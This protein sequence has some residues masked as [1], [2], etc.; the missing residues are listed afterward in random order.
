[1]GSDYSSY[2]TNRFTSEL[3]QCS[4]SELSCAYQGGTACLTEHVARCAA[5]ALLVQGSTTTTAAAVVESSDSGMKSAVIILSVV[6]GFFVV[7][8]GVLLVI[9]FHRRQT[10]VEPQLPGAAYTTPSSPKPEKSASV[11]SS[12]SGLQTSHSDPLPAVATEGS[13]TI[14][15]VAPQPTSSHI[16]PHASMKPRQ[17]N[18]ARISDSNPETLARQQMK[19]RRIIT[20]LKD[21]RWQRGRLLGRGSTGAVFLCILCDGS[22]LAM[23][24]ID[25]HSSTKE[26][27]ETLTQELRMMASLRDEHIIRYYHAEYSPSEKVVNLWMEYC[28]GGALG[29]LVKKLDDRLHEDVVQHYVKQILQGIAFLHCHHIVHRDIKGDNILIESEGI[30]KLADFGSAKRLTIKTT[31]ATHTNVTNTIVGT[32]L[33]MAPEVVNP[34]SEYAS[35][36]YNTKAD[37]WSLGITVA[38]LLDQGR[39][40]WP[41]FTS[42]WAALF[43]IG[44]VMERPLLPK[45]SDICSDF[46]NKCLQP[47]PHDRP[48][49]EQLLQHPWMVNAGE[50]DPDNFEWDPNFTTSVEFQQ[51]IGQA[52]RVPASGPAEGI[53]Y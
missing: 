47:N 2:C 14:I 5:A 9:V 3:Q 16:S 41:E 39:P 32:P 40:P 42:A 52:G 36:G 50:D 19:T 49:A 53:Q 35:G 44:N 18:R 38:E 21:G 12:Q 4:S 43:H 24:Q 10:Q 23:K 11:A 22:F 46:M 37:I 27:A 7:V 31:T 51:A 13:G 34:E 1:M 30:V 15:H 6:M 17:K 8:I 28:H 33:W 48:T 20:M 26:E 45:V 29:A 25:M